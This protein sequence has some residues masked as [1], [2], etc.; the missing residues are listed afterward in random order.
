VPEG[1]AGISDARSPS[2]LAKHGVVR[3]EEGRRTV[4]VGAPHTAAVRT[5][6]DMGLEIVAV[7]APHRDPDCMAAAR[8]A[9]GAAGNRGGVGQALAR[10]DWDAWPET[11]RFMERVCDLLSA[12]EATLPGPDNK[13]LNAAP[14]LPASS[15]SSGASATSAPCPGQCPC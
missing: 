5:L 9:G 15:S 3:C 13:S 12:A 10:G 2:G 4:F 6:K 1:K 14:V 11:K 7:A 8:L